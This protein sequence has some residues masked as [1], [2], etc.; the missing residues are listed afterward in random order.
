MPRQRRPRRHLGRTNQAC[1]ESSFAAV[2]NLDHALK[3]LRRG[4][5]VNYSMVE[6]E[7]QPHHRAPHDLAPMHR[8]LIDYSSDPE[9]TS[10]ARIQ[11]WRE[12]IDAP[13]P[14][15]GYGETAAGHVF[16]FQMTSARLL[17]ESAAF[18]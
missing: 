6:G 12:R 8:G 5:A 17:A 11:D 15:V 9:N 1:R 3:K 14:E 2:E 10:L 16:K 18:E 7:A 13:R 4:C